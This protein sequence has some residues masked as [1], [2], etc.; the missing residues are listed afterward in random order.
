MGLL[1]PMANGVRF[2]TVPQPSD[3][4]GS[5][6][7]SIIYPSN[8]ISSVT[9]RVLE[10]Q[11]IFEALDVLRMGA[12]ISLVR[13]YSCW[14]AGVRDM[15]YHPV[16]E[17]S[18]MSPWISKTLLVPTKIAGITMHESKRDGERKGRQ[19]GY[20]Q[21]ARAFGHNRGGGCRGLGKSLNR[22]GFGSGGEGGVSYFCG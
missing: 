13:F 15:G 11:N 1:R 9:V 8:L 16:M 22:G 10:E 7:W 17:V 18:T 19:A 2:G 20:P 12:I 4:I 5:G 21:M 3:C 14:L 6:K